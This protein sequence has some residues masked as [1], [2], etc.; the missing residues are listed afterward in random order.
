MA[1]SQ[2]EELGDIRRGRRVTRQV[3]IDLGFDRLHLFLRMLVGV[4]NQV[5]SHLIDDAPAVLSGQ[6]H[7]RGW[8]EADLLL[9]HALPMKIVAARER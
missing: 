4:L 8:R 7:D 2:L 6:A 3:G 9:A 1:A 5:E